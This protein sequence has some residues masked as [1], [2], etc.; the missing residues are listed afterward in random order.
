MTSKL[1]MQRELQC[2]LNLK[3]G[4]IMYLQLVMSIYTAS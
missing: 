2:K 1:V 4:Q 3:Q